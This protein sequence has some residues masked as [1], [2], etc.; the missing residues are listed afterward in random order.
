[1]AKIS[2]QKRDSTGVKVVDLPAGSKLTAFVIVHLED[3]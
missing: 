2:R 3:E 1:V